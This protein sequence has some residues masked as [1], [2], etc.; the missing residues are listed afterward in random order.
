[1]VSFTGSVETG[2]K[3]MAAAAPNITKV[4]LELGGKA[5]A[6]VLAD[7]DLDLAVKAIK[8]SR[9]INSG[10]VCNCAERVYVEKSVADEFTEK[11]KQA[12]EAVTVGDP[13][14]HPDIDMGPVINEGALHKIQD[15]VNLAV[16]EGAY[17]AAGGQIEDLGN[18]GFYFQPTVIS[19]CGADMDIMRKEIFGPVLPIQTVDSLDEA[20][21]LSNDSEYGLTSSIYTKSLSK[22]MYAIDRIDF[23]ETYIN[24]ENFEAMQ[25]FHAGTRK[26]GIGGA[27]GKHGLY[28]YTHTHVV[29]IE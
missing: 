14:A 6:I 10:Q 22:A 15:K 2:E 19:G 18:H 16:K 17:I 23:G 3:I 5:P 27:D 29:Y 24:R 1:M 12:M 4:N 26:S 8:D 7:A 21:E 13:S 28:E 11:M 25:G 9:I 20:I